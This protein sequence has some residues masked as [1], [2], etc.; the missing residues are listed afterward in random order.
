MFLKFISLNLISNCIISNTTFKNNNQNIFIEN[1]IFFGIYS[2]GYG[3]S[4]YISNE[5]YY[6]N[7]NNT[8][9]FQCWTSGI[10]GGAIFLNG[11]ECNFNKICGLYCKSNQYDQFAYIQVLNNKNNF[12]NYVSISKC[13]ND[14]YKYYTL[15]EINGIQNISNMNCS[16]NFNYEDSGMILSSSNNIF[17]IYCTFSNN[18]VTDS[19]CLSL[20]GSIINFYY[21]N[22]INNNSPIKNGVI[23][24]GSGINTMNYCIFYNNL[25]TL[26]YINS[27]SLTLNNCIF[28]QN[29]LTLTTNIGN[30]PI[31]L[32]LTSKFTNT[33]NLNHYNTFFNYLNHEILCY[34][35]NLTNKLNLNSN[36]LKKKL[37]LKILNFYILK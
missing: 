15:R 6:L 34:G 20:S 32:P 19:T 33:F 30:S 35:N 36:N 28:N 16:F 14:S 22:I 26:I 4:I 31:F 17:C 2:S 1:C 8:I 13:Y 23:T 27:G 12:L 24:I 7:L 25:N 18:S 11:L 37:I 21:S 10:I 29:Y 9:F 3:G 5:N